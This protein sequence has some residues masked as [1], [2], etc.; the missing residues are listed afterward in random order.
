MFIAD[1]LSHAHKS[2][3][4]PSDLFDYELEVFSVT[5][6]KEKLEELRK[7]T[8]ENKTLQKLRNAVKYGW[9]KDDVI[10]R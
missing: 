1:V 2:D 10:L 8:A 3:T 4:S 9:P 7:A 6:T 5:M